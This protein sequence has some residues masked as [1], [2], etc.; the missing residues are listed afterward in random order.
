[1]SSLIVEVCRIQ[2]VF[3][4]PNADALELAHIKGWQCVV[5]K[6]RFA[7]G[8]LVTY[9]PIDSVLPL[10]LSDRIGV[11]KYLSNGR[12]RCARLRGEPSFGVVI[13]AEP[14]L[15]EGEDVK[16]RYGI[17]KFIPPMKITSG[18]AEQPHALFVNYTDIENM[19]NFPEVFQPGEAVV[20]SEKLHG[21]NCRVGIVTEDDGTKIA[22]AGSKVVRRKR[23][24]DDQL[25]GDLYWHPWSLPSVKALVESLAAKHRQ[26]LLFGEVYGKV[27]SL[28]YGLSNGI[29]FAAFDLLLDGRFA[30][31]DEFIAICEQFG[32]ARVPVIWSGG[33]DLAKIRELSDGKTTIVG[34]ENIREGVVVR[35][36]VERVDP[37]IGRAIL[38]YVGDRYLLGTDISDLVDV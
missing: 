28:R 3:P 35:P 17:T 14:G 37:K 24:S 13:D 4:H 12:V 32:V 15:V 36:V 27:Q 21:T 22:V 2:N 16:G 29:A 7:V 1:M 38:K 34:A 10:E 18:D 6:G 31:N 9:I 23:P 25:A 33:F 20:A 19:R 8:Q 5:P 26:V 30:D 11:T